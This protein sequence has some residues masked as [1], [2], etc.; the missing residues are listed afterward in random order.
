[1]YVNYDDICKMYDM[2]VYMDVIIHI[3]YIGYKMCLY[4]LWFSIADRF[5]FIG[6]FEINMTKLK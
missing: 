3:I 4:F 6:T 1:M 2:D 5:D